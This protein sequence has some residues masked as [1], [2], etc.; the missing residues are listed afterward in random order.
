[1]SAKR[2]VIGFALHAYVYNVLVTVLLMR[3]KYDFYRFDFRAFYQFKE[4][5][6]NNDTLLKYELILNILMFVPI[7]FLL[8]LFLKGWSRF[9]IS[10]ALCVMF[11]LFI[12]TTQLFTR[13]GEFQTDDIIANSMGGII[14]AFTAFVFYK[15]FLDKEEEDSP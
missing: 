14:G 8:S 11:T 13:L 4:V 5:F 10:G 7:G 9:L 3:D 15:I 6:Y 12:E 1:M 2:W